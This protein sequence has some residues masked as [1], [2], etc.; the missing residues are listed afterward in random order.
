V[1]GWPLLL[2]ALAAC[3]RIGFADGAGSSADALLG[4]V[5]ADALVPSPLHR[6]R[7]AGNLDDDFGGPNLI[8]LAPGTFRDAGYE[9]AANAGLSLDA[10]AMPSQVYTLDLEVSLDAVT[11]W[12]KLVDFDGGALDRGLYV[13]EAALQDVIVPL[14]MESPDFLTSAAVL[15]PSVPL[16]ITVTRD[17]ADHVTGYVRHAPVK[18]ARGST[19]TVPANPV[20]PFA[21]DDLGDS[22]RVN[23]SSV[24]WFV[25]D[26]AT[27][28]G[29]ASGGMVRLI[30]IWDV[31]LTDA[32]IASL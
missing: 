25:D 30:T 32:Q 22:L 9:F 27:G 29:E 31:A 1:L 8:A 15:A 17:A 13:Y 26:D 28:G 16:R 10:A 3:G 5:A 21:Y 18:A 11:S 7:F 2:C 6:Y 12:R 20:D 14:G 24:R 4:D 19:E 23:A